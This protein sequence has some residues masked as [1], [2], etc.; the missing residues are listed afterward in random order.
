MSKTFKFDKNKYRRDDDYYD[1]YRSSSNYSKILK[2]RMTSALK[3]RDYDA[4]DY[5]SDDDLSYKR[6]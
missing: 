4:L 5:Y 6:R 3:K 1:D 2:K